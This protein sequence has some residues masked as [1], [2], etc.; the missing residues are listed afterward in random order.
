MRSRARCWSMPTN[1]TSRSGQPVV[2]E[3]TSEDVIHNFWVP[4]LSGK[5]DMIPGRTNLH[6]HP[7]RRARACT[8]ALCAEF[9][10]GPHALMGVQ[11]VAH[12]PGEFQRWLAE[13]QSRAAA[14]LS[15]GAQ[16]GEQLFASLGC[17]ACHR[18]AG[19]PYDGA[20][21]ARPQPRRP[22]AHA[23]RRHPAQQPR[24]ADGLDRQLARRSSPATACRPTSSS[25]GEDLQAVAEYLEAQR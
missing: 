12:E 4:R 25:G 3:L 5:L 11:V 19:T 7:G 10:G 13:R 9:C 21:R 23:R 17:A 6:A 18:I 16:R 15:A 2:L 24:H 8:A 1:C 14:A 20:G 22:A